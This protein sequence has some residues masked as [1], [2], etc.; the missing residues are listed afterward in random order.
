MCLVLCV[1]KGTH[2]PRTMVGVRC[3]L[4]VSLP[5]H[6]SK[7][8]GRLVGPVAEFLLTASIL[9]K[10]CWAW[11]WTFLKSIFV[12][13][14]WC[15]PITDSAQ[16][17]TTRPKRAHLLH[18]RRVYPHLPFCFLSSTLARLFFVFS[19]SLFSGFFA[20]ILCRNSGPLEFDASTVASFISVRLSGQMRESIH[21]TLTYAITIRLWH[22]Q[23]Q[24]VCRFLPLQAHSWAWHEFLP[25]SQ[26]SP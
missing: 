10:Y 8:V 13:N 22:R 19:H 18:W 16:L 4:L 21:N 23:S 14:C 6:W 9:V 2:W 12:S 26:G 1:K 20:R 24:I 3:S 11:A 15:L 7:G 17:T 5:I 25:S